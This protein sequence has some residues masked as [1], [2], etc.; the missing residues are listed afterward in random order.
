MSGETKIKARCPVC[1]SAYRVASKSLGHKARCPK[2]DSTFRLAAP[3]Q[4]TRK[5]SVTED[6]ILAWL[7]E[8]ADDDM[9][10]EPTHD[11]EKTSLPSASNGTSSRWPARTPKD[12]GKD[13]SDKGAPQPSEIADA[14]AGDG[15]TSPNHTP[16]LRKTG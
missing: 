16:D 15:G 12:P 4:K 7:N 3:P 5:P 13:T 10:T 1:K 8:G 14:V 2:C 6:D 11:R 9:I